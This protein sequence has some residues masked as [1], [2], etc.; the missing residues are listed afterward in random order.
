MKVLVTGGAGFIGTYTVK[1]LLEQGYQVSVVDK[2]NCS[3]DDERLKAS[4]FYTV[5]IEDPALEDVFEKEKPEAVIHLAAQIDVQHSIHNPIDDATDNII[6]TINVLENC[7]KYKV[8]KVVYSSS[9]AVY[10]RPTSSII[11]ED[12]PLNPVSPYGISKLT[13]EYYIKYYAHVHGMSYAILR[14]ANVYGKLHHSS[15][16]GGVISIFIN[17]LLKG[18][19]PI[20]FGDGEQKRDFIYIEDVAKANVCAVM[21][22]D[23][24]TANISTNTSTSLNELLTEL[25]S[26]LDVKI[27]PI[28]VKGRPGEI[29]D[30]RLSNE[31]ANHYL[32][33]SPSYNLQTGIKA[34]LST[35][36]STKT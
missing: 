34:T 17:Q 24:I 27:H 19:S 13:P 4:S 15:G 29:R 8:R 30:S 22:G 2:A 1:Q 21:K 9:A 6:G 3:I 16:E 32:Q 12:H 31:L 10:G 7:R 25:K 35:Y 11:D 28:Y 18:E 14:Y 5:N 20:I 36:N 26:R 23:D 33:W